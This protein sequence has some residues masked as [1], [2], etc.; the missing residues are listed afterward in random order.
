MKTDA[1][2][3]LD[4]LRLARSEGV[5][6]RTFFG[7]I[8][9]FGDAKAAL[10]ALP[11]LARARNQVVRIPGLAEIE[12]ELREAER[13]GA[14]HLHFHDPDYP[15]SLRQ[16]EGAPPVIALLGRADRLAMPLVGMVGTRN[17]SAL[18][19]KMAGILARELGE[20]GFGIVSGLARGIDTEAHRA[21]LPYGTVAV[22]AGGLDRPYP[23][24]NLELM[25]KISEVGAV[26]SEMPFGLS[27]RG[28]DFPRRNRLI[29]GLAQGVL[30]VEAARRSGSLITARYALEQGREVFAVPGSPLDPRAE[31]SNDLLREGASI[32]TCTADLLSVLRPM[33][34]MMPRSPRFFA[35]SGK[36]AAY[37]ELFGPEPDLGLEALDEGEAAAEA[38]PA[39]DAKAALLALLSTSP[40]EIDELCRHLAQP[41]R[42]VQALLT[43]LEFAGAIER[44]AGNRVARAIS[45]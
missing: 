36:V 39:L 4:W 34:G 41:I 16:I 44:Q 2:G 42:H 3:R 10:A 20:A 45:S 6:P 21:S 8:D 12:A 14:R 13:L 43:E 40:V 37:N 7:L 29:A 26:I 15:E 19:R 38:E 28:K 17:A 27:P 33:A 1:P 25:R 22:L 24:E 5:G 30:V 32:V 35:E 9:R 11:A 23:P 18:G 31:G